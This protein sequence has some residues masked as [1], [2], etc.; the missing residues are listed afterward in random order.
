M[1]IKIAQLNYTAGDINGNVDKMLKVV[2]ECED[3]DLLVFSEMSLTGYPIWDSM[4]LPDFTSN[5]AKA[6]ARFAKESA[7]L[8]PGTT[9]VIG[10]MRDNK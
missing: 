9:I 5:V 6:E 2:S 1:N 3:I 7:K 8:A 4:L 10:S